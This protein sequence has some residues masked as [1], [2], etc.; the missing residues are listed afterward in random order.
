MNISY[1]LVSLAVF[2]RTGRMRECTEGN[3]WPLNKLGLSPGAKRYACLFL[4]LLGRDLDRSSPMALAR[5]RRI[6]KELGLS[7]IQLA[8]KYSNQLLQP[9]SHGVGRCLFCAW[10][11][12]AWQMVLGT[13]CIELVLR[14][15]FSFFF[16]LFS[17]PF[18]PSSGDKHGR[19]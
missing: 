11:G 5:S 7:S 13:C 19:H 8:L 2:P 10:Q 12:V 9:S 4:V 18:P 6:R 15:G 3:R 1:S 17:S 14:S 16:F